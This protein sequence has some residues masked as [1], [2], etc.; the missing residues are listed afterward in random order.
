MLR[1]KGGNVTNALQL[2]SILHHRNRE[3]ERR[4]LA[5]LRFH[6]DAP[7]VPLDDLF[8]HGQ[9]DARSRVLVPGVQSLEDHKNSPEVLRLDP[10]AIVAHAENP[11]PL[12]GFHAHVN[13]RR[14][15]APELDPVA[16]EIL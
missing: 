7:A 11:I 2:L 5:W 6:P 10:N 13:A 8:T 4:S 16:H 3:K 9:P 12:S 15:V 14:F 1:T